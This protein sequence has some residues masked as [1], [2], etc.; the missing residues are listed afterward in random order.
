[1]ASLVCS[2]MDQAEGD[3][4]SAVTGRRCPEAN[5]FHYLAVSLTLLA[6][7]DTS[8]PVW[9]FLTSHC[10]LRHLQCSDMPSASRLHCAAY[11]CCTCLPHQDPPVEKL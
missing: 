3:Q 6:N 1:M 8:L 4:S 10:C 11:G 7:M 5:E 2:W 9:A